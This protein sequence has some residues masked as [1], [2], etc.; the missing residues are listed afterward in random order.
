MTGHTRMLQITDLHL[1]TNSHLLYDRIDTWQRLCT[2]LSAA[3]HFSPDAVLVTGDLYNNASLAS[4]ELAVLFDKASHELACP[5]I[6]L[7]G[8]HDDSKIAARPMDPAALCPLGQSLA[9]MSILLATC[10][11][12]R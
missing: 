12:L 4:T 11:W 6:A 2:A 9:T 5:V 8:N 3:D 10:A 7:P 1:T